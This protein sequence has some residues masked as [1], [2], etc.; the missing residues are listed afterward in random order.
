MGLAG[1]SSPRLVFPLTGACLSGC[2]LSSL[3]F[4]SRF[5]FIRSISFCFFFSNS[6]LRLSSLFSSRCF[7][8]SSRRCMI[9]STRG[10]VTLVFPLAIHKHAK[11]LIF[12][13][14]NMFKLSFFY[15]SFHAPFAQAAPG[16]IQ[17]FEAPLPQDFPAS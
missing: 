9:N 10:V 11:E 1:L 6:F 13:S 4:P 5:L 15:L 14:E 3:F 7:S 17:H 16:K 2:L 8:R 12:P